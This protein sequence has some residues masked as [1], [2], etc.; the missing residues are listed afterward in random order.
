[1]FR[2]QLNA[3]RLGGR[4]ASKGAPSVVAADGSCLYHA[5]VHAIQQSKAPVE[6][7]YRLRRALGKYI[8]D[9]RTALNADFG[10]SIV[11]ATLSR[12]LRAEWGENDEVAILSRMLDVCIVV[13]SRIGRDSVSYIYDRG[14][15]YSG[16]DAEGQTA[17]AES[18]C[19]LRLVNDH[20]VHYDAL[21]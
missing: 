19:V 12:V 18:T 11:E 10:D 13:R 9:N 20:G 16:A 17:E 3:S 15:M 7:G 14:K 5:V 1:M 4:A 8:V 21:V 6:E 2:A